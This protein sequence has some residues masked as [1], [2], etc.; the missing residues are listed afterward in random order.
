METVQRKRIELV[1]LRMIVLIALTAVP[2]T[3][4]IVLGAYALWKTGM[5]I[6]LWWVL[7]AGWALTYLLVKI[8]PAKPHADAVPPTAKHWT[9]RDREAAEIVLGY[10]HQIESL[11]PEQ[12]TD[13]QFYL[14]QFQ[15]LSHELA[16]YYHPEAADPF[17]SL[18]I[19]ELSAAVRLVADDIEQ[20]VLHSLPGSRLLTVKQW[21]SFG[22]T[23]QWA[24]RI[25]NSVWAGSILINPL[26]IARYGVSRGTIDKVSSGIQSELL[27]TIYLRFIRQVG[28][29][30]IEM[31]SGRLR[32]GADEYRS[33]FESSQR[34]TDNFRSSRSDTVTIGVIG[35]VSAG[36][37]SLINGITGDANATV[38][39][40]PQTKST[41]RYSLP[42]DQ[43]PSSRQMNIV[44]LDSPGYQQHGADD[45]QLNEIET[46]LV[47]SDMILLTI[48][49]HSPA[50]SADV[51]TLQ[52]IANRF[53]K[54]PH[55]KPPPIIVVL[56][57][58]DLLS[59]AREWSPPYHLKNPTSAKEKSIAGA[60]QY[61]REVFNRSAVDANNVIDIVDVVAVCCGGDRDR[62]WGIA[63]QLMPMLVD[64]LEEGKSAAILQAF[65]SAIDQ[66]WGKNVWEQITT[67]GKQLAKMWLQEKINRMGK[68]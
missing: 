61:T 6:W 60:I 38:D 23:P 26:N 19:P 49:A 54:I 66:G 67:G 5:L 3:L 11:T 50:R 55:L 2:M 47:E 20:L 24:N 33:A 68:K 13:A 27:A 10:Q 34:W 46:A 62:Q 29:Y 48:D 21:R 32:G 40:L 31:N 25:R 56:T 64:Q 4:Y 43:S 36:K 65:E 14:Q 63:E 22:K 12:L 51:E 30:L 28:F 9:P 1:N 41:K 59:P 53:E 52:K 7:P 37:S 15:Q 58:I 42:L 16:T 39:L 17:S 44:L 57:H 45:Q 35:Q 8:W 18:T